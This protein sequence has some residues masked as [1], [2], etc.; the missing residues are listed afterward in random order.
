MCLVASLPPIIQP[1]RTPRCSRS[2][3]T[4]GPFVLFLLSCSSLLPEFSSSSSSCKLP[5]NWVPMSSSRK[6]SLN[7][8]AFLWASRAGTSKFR[9]PLRLIFFPFVAWQ[10]AGSASL[11]NSPAEQAD[12]VTDLCRFLLYKRPFPYRSVHRHVV[13]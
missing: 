11:N 1:R 10:M 7:L 5:Q 3:L 6:P 13:V 2:V 12:I 9:W 8:C 4:A